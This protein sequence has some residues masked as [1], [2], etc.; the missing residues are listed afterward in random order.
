MTDQ[1]LT[2]TQDHILTI[3]INRPASKNAITNEMYD[4]L[5]TALADADHDDDVRVIVLV[6]NA[7]SFTAGNDL[8]D[9]LEG[10][11]DHENNPVM[12]FLRQLSTTEKPIV[13]GVRGVAIGIG[14]TMLLHCDLV[15]AAEDARFQL[16]FVNLGLCPEAA[17]SYL[18]PLAAG[19]HLASELLLT[20]RPFGPETAWRCGLVNKI[21]E[22][23]DVEAEALKFAGRIASFPIASVTLTKRLLKEPHLATVERVMSNEAGHFQERLHSPEAKEAFSAFLE[24]RPPDFSKF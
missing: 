15:V 21:V 9:F 8:K 14:T 24:K 2:D 23:E 16:P 6:G 1:I 4:A 5:T 18:L 11:G 20:G 7:D 13:V 3:R 17:S 19:F 10:I 22:S 12:K